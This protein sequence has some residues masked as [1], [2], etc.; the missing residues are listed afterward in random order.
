MMGISQIDVV[1][2]AIVGLFVGA[3]SGMLGIGGGILVIPALTVIFGLSQK[4][5]VGTSITMLLP[6]IGV[7]AF[8]EYRRA[9]QVN[10]P[11]AI[12]LAIFFAIG[13]FG[14]GR[15]ATRP[16]LPSGALRMLFGFFLLYVGCS[17]VFRADSRVWVSIKTMAV[18]AVVGLI[19]AVG[20]VMGRRWEYP[21]PAAMYRAKVAL[22]TDKPG[23]T[24]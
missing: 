10:I 4:M 16:W 18:V 2:L 3:L 5:A 14:G 22:A 24:S 19:Y 11:F 20:R 6:P 23:E 13:G 1:K 9:G 15:L 12:V 17:I 7:F 8:L 21:D